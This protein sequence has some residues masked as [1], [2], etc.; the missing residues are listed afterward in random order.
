MLPEREPDPAYLVDPTGRGGLPAGALP[1]VLVGAGGIARDAHLPAYR[2]AGLAVAAVVDLDVDRARE[3]AAE[4]G[5]P[6]T[7]P[8][9]A[10]A[11]A[12][13]GTGVVYDV[14]VM[15]GAFASI[16]EAL[17]DG[18]AVQLQKPLGYTH[19]QARELVDL[20]GR[21]R[22]TASVNTQL[23]FAPHVAAARRLI[24]DGA[25]GE[26]ID[27][28]VLV[29]VETRWEL[30]PSVFELDRMEMPMHSVHYVDLVRSFVGD[31]SGVSA[32]TVRHPDKP[33]ASTRSAYLL[34]YADRPLRV[35]ISTNH[36]HTFGPEHQEAAVLWHGTAGAIRAQLGLLLD[37]PRG[38]PDLLEV[39][40]G[41]G[42]RAV[43][44]EGS[45]FPDAFGATMG[46]LQRY[47]TGASRTLPTAASDV[48]RTMA[49]LE[50][51]HEASR[52]GGH[53]LP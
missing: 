14:A 48:L 49:V 20:I 41:T 27:L 36:D 31:P 38:G 25:I 24:A 19:A 30:F 37:Y 7:H 29:R 21:K 17:P 50:A 40:T 15:P 26:L 13:H 45:W 51:A 16:L 46:A 52:A 23:R 5:V 47:V 2:K 6:T 1:I 28:E 9:I 22:L 44:V 10:A 43:E 42:W 12:A 8:D 18:A 34:H 3:L 4:F 11:V 35:T 33:L 39:N 53:P 32:V